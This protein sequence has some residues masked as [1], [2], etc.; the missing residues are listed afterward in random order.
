[1]EMVLMTGSE[2]RAILRDEINLALSQQKSKST[3]NG[4]DD[5]QILRRKDIAQ[6]FSVSLVTVHSWM[7][8]GQIPFHRI[9]G[10]TFFKKGE[11]LNAMKEAKMRRRSIF[12]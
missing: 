11:V 3:L 8:S 10:R 7:K 6:I 12:K 4:T 9:G 5:D 1:M 2:L